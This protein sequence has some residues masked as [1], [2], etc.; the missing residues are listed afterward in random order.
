I[1][2]NV[3][4]QDIDIPDP[5]PE[6]LRTS[7]GLLGLKEALSRVHFPWSDDPLVD[8]EDAEQ[9]FQSKP[10]FTVAYHELFMLQLG[11][12]IKRKRLNQAR[13]I[14]FKNDNKL[15]GELL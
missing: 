4:D 14:S 1:V 5:V 13:G 2:R 15:P 10:H 8:I 3:V 6:R 11:L 7:R 12:A 9:I